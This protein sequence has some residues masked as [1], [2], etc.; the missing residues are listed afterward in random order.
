MS[1][2]ARVGEEGD[3][4][5]SSNP[6]PNP[7]KRFQDGGDV[8]ILAHPHQDSYIGYCI[9]MFLIYSYLRLTHHSYCPLEDCAANVEDQEDREKIVKNHNY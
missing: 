7:V 5:L 1:V 6:N 2:N 4:V 3:L 9:I 8:I